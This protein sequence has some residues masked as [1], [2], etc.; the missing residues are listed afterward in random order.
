LQPQQLPQV[1][2]PLSL[3]VDSFYFENFTIKYCCWFVF[4][5]AEAAVPLNR[6]NAVSHETEYAARDDHLRRRPIVSGILRGNPA[7][8][9]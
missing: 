7:P 1:L 4:I 8:Q 5:P 6:I 2:L 9:H 3:H